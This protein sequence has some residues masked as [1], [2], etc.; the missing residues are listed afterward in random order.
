[1]RTMALGSI[2]VG[3]ALACATGW[4]SAQT[5]Y[6]IVGPDGRVT[7][8]DRAPTSDTPSQSV[9]T[10]AVTEPT[11]T[12]LSDL[13]L[14][15]KQ[16]ATKYPLTFYT[17]KDCGACDTARRYL[18]TRGVPFTEKTVTSNEEIQALRKLNP[19]GTIPFA[20]LGAQHLSGFNENDWSAYLDAAG[21]PAQSK[22]PSSYRPAPAQ[23]LIP[24]VIAPAAPAAAQPAAPSGS[25]AP[26]NQNVEPERVTPSN[27]TGIV[28]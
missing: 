17:S 9:S 28:F 13:P 8:S 15:V 26:G 27:P 14:E 10:G 22:L 18:L 4:A 7:F 1:M 16:A 2:L 12:R 25:P 6:R 23:P 19:D 21:Y 11:G 5:V 20:T 3:T 24:K